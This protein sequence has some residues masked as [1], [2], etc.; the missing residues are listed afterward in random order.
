[1]K[2]FVELFRIQEESIEVWFPN[3]RGSVRVRLKDRSELVFT[4]NDSKRW[5]LETIESFKEGHLAQ[6][7]R[8]MRK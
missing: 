2:K 4:F 8:M 6:A 7:R 3:G 1:M 5:R